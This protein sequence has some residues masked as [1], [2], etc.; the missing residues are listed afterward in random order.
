MRQLQQ[1]VANSPNVE[2]PSIYRSL[3]FF[4]E[5]R[6]K[7]DVEE[8]HPQH[9]HITPYIIAVRRCRECHVSYT[10]THSTLSSHECMH[11]REAS[12]A[13]LYRGRTNL[14]PNYR[15]RRRPSTVDACR[16][17]AGRSRCVGADCATEPCVFLIF[18]PIWEII[19]VHANAHNLLSRQNMILSNIVVPL[20]GGFLRS[21][22]QE[23]VD[24]WPK[25]TV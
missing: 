18:G 4:R 8:P 5:F 10:S 20:L 2:P 3:G 17:G 14:E 21:L 12:T 9:G 22:A 13:S 1:Y 6:V 19:M 7:V 15:A 16:L 24:E 11:V 25:L 23:C